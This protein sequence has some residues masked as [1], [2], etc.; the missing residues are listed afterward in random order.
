MFVTVFRIR[1]ILGFPGMDP[2]LFVQIRTRVLLST[3]KK[4]KT[5]FDIYSIVQ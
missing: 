5:N 2:V 1:Q 3:S 4:I